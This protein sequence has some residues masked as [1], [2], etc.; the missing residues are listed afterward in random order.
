MMMM[1][2]M[3][4]LKINICLFF[5]FLFV[6]YFVFYFI[7]FVCFFIAYFL[8]IYKEWKFLYASVLD[9]PM[10]A[11]L[12]RSVVILLLLCLYVCLHVQLFYF[13][14]LRKKKSRTKIHMH[15]QQNLGGLR[16]ASPPP[17]FYE[18]YLR[19]KEKI[20]A[21]KAYLREERNQREKKR[22]EAKREQND[23]QT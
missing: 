18:A 22:Q 17:T 23:K 20:E 6:V 19:R 1:L 4:V 15:H 11:K 10:V 21:Q 8:H 14:F 2:M 3:P 13:S 7:L 12:K 5:V 16:S 9:A